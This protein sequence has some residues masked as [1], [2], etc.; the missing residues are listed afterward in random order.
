MIVLIEHFENN[1]K[2]QI[3]SIKRLNRPKHDKIFYLKISISVLAGSCR[4]VFRSN[5][6]NVIL[7][8]L[9]RLLGHRSRQQQQ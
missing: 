2:Q 9:D 1:N 7:L 5:I 8:R 4:F 3:R 6:D